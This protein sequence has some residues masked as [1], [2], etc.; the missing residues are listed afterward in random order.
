[1]RVLFFV[2]LASSLFAQT[3]SVL[4][5]QRHLLQSTQTNAA[6]APDRRVVIGLGGLV[7]GVDFGGASYADV[8]RQRNGRTVLDVGFVLDQMGVRNYLREDFSLET[9]GVGV[10]FGDAAVTFQHRVRAGAFLD[11]PRNLAEVIWRGN[12]QFIGQTVDLS[13]QIDVESYHELALGFSYQLGKLR[14]GARAKYLN[15]IAYARTL[16]G[17]LDL[18]TDE[19]AYQLTL[20]TDYELQTAGLLRYNSITD[21][22]VAFGFQTD[23]FSTFFGGNHG[24]ALD[25]GATYT[26]GR[27]ELAASVVDVASSIDW[28]QQT[29]TLTSER[30]IQYAGLDLSGAI[31]GESVDLENALDT[32]EQLLEFDVDAGAFSSRLARRFYLSGRYEWT[33][34]LETGIALYNRDRTFGDNDLHITIYGG[35]RLGKLLHL[36]LSY[37]A[38]RDDANNIG[39]QLTTTLGPVRLFALTDDLYGLTEYRNRHNANF[40]VGLNVGFGQLE[41]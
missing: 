7:A 6:F 20:T 28:S 30:T 1:M 17:G 31:T 41:E 38:K 11:Y 10:R 19:D 21:V 39:A 18:F 35:Y 27:L 23:D 13:H 40:R 36:G 26:T 5:F 2:F 16:R 34:Q 12:A 8:F 24:Y 15:G 4:H 14:L 33:D 29:Q 37:T 22:D 3:E 25:F 32:L 9:L